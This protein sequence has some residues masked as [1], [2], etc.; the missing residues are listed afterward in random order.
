MRACVLGLLLLLGVAAASHLPL[1]RFDHDTRSLLRA[2]A[3]EDRREAILKERFGSDDIL[4]VAWEVEDALEPETFARIG[5]ITRELA[6][7]DGLEEMYSIASPRVLLPLTRNAL[8]RPIADADLATPEARE[9]VAEALRA[10]PVYVGTIC[11]ESL[12]VVAAAGT[13]AP[14][15]REERE[16][17]IRAV[18]AVA[19]RHGDLHV[20]GVT[21]LA[22]AASEYA[23]ADL[24]EVGGAALLVSIVV[25]LI[26]CGSFRETLI[27]VVATGLPPLLTLGLAAFL[28]WPIT[29]LGAAL[30]PVLAV[31]GITSAV[32]L[33]NAYGIERDGRAAARRVAPPILLSLATTALAFGALRFTGVPAFRAAGTL[34]GAGVLIAIP[35]VL[36]GVP[37]MLDLVRPPARRRLATRLDRPLVALYRWVARRPRTVVAGALILA[38][39]AVPLA[40]GA[41]VQ[42]DVLQSFEPDSD[43]ARTYRFL[44]DKLTATLPV[45]LVVEAG[46]E[47]PL[48]ELRAFETQALAVPGVESALGLQSLVAYGRSITPLGETAALT[49]LRTALARITER[50]EHRESGSYRV[51]LRVR[52]GTP[53]AVLDELEAVRAS[54]ISSE[55]S[56]TGLYVRAVRTTRALI[57]DLAKATLLMIA[58]VSLIVG[59]ALRS[60]RFAIAAALPNLL[61]PL[62][63]FAGAALAGVALDVSAVAVGGVAVGL[64]VDDSIHMLF[65]AR[66]GALRPA[67]LRAQRT[68]GRALVLSTLVLASGLVCLLASSFLPTARFGALAAAASVVALLADLIVLPAALLVLRR[69]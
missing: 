66:R 23:V 2:D 63:V 24:L 6:A 47:P 17:T 34:V 42:V 7:I 44:E 51:K 37:A 35:V 31:V 67:L 68:V 49:F 5:A 62:L 30:F 22:L 10:A 65:A 46:P 45:D 16:A 64:A 41:P 20:S 9:I 21:A 38:L 40:W 15:P 59:L 48:A 61:A 4:L 25:L 53:P 12:T 1:L 69:L 8:P 32:H 55:S 58:I 19:R 14:G 3:S 27:A 36:L 33:L 54:T 57:G 13:L 60:V 28:G 43:I 29:A 18:R 39:A 52:E 11:N 56:Y 26:L 50:F